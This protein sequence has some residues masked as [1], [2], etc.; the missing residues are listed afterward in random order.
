[1]EKF[2]EFNP[3]KSFIKILFNRDMGIYIPVLSVLFDFCGKC[4]N[5]CPSK[6]IEFVDIHEAAL[7]RK[8]VKLPSFPAP[9]ISS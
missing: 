8:K 5:N 3:K 7:R 6:A 2:G 9:L 1:M 4:V